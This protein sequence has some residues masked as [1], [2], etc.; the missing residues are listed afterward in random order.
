MNKDISKF[1]NN[2]KLEILSALEKIVNMDS[3]T[4]YKEGVDAL[5]DF[6]N[7]KFS[8]IGFE[9]E[10][11]PQEKYG[12]HLI[13]RHK[14]EGNNTLIIGHFDTA[15]PKGS[16]K[17]R[18]FKIIENRGYGCG[19]SD[20]K[21][22]IIAAFFAI[23]SV[24]ETTGLKPNITVILNSDEEPGS[25]TSRQIIK[26]EAS[27]ASRAFIM[28]PSRDNSI[29]TQRKGVGIFTFKAKGV[30]AHAGSE[31]ENGRS[32]IVELGHMILELS[33]LND[34]KSGITVNVGVIEGG[35]YPYVVAEE[36]IAK[37]DCRIPTEKDGEYLKTKFN[38]IINLSKIEG[39]KRSWKGD[40]HR[41]P[42]EKNKKTTELFEFVNKIASMLNMP[43][44]KETSDGAV[45]D[46]NLTS[47][48]GIPTLDGMGSV[49]AGYHGPKEYVE[50]DSIISRTELLAQVLYKLY[51]V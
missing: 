3:A 11:I 42:M 34:Y 36:A 46:G 26:R 31:P 2:K 12:N 35:T 10:K 50:I 29:I 22:G 43:L 9:V 25:P 27:K 6:L 37:V 18:P 21:A 7:Q 1:V 30:A 23:K 15:L 47:S 38:E 44:L 51:K 8:E 5:G 48:M 19:V 40:F 32:A 16:P 41:P 45:S 13:C 20:M 33:R 4:E 17:K 39:V 24:L 14:G 28:E 49:G